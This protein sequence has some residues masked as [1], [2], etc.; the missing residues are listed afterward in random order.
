MTCASANPDHRLARTTFFFMRLLVLP[1]NVKQNL[2]VGLKCN[3]RPARGLGLRRIPA[4]LS[5]A[6]KYKPLY[7]IFYL[8]YLS[9]ASTHLSPTQHMFGLK[10]CLRDPLTQICNQSVNRIL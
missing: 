6:T 4:P 9:S 3:E 2:N 1:N 10:Y 8:S 5:A 7:Y